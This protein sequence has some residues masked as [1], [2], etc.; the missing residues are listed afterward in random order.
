VKDKRL[1]FS[2]ISVCLP[3]LRSA[4]WSVLPRIHVYAFSTL[5]EDPIGDI[6]RRSAG[7]L[8]CAPDSIYPGAGA[9]KY[10]GPLPQCEGHIVRDVAPKKVMVCLSFTLPE[11]VREELWSHLLPPLC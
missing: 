10:A 4:A 3:C 2:L 9:G 1:T 6:V 11:E 8:R 5:V 7:V